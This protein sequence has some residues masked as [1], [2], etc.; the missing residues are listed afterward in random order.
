MS[1]LIVLDFESFYD[2]TYSLS[3]ITT[4]HYIRDP[5]F[6]A[7]GVSVKVNDGVPLWFSGPKPAIKKFLDQFPWDEATAV[8]HN[9][10]FDMAILNWHFDIR[11]KRIAC[12]LSMGRALH[13]I[14][15]G[16]LS[17]KALAEKYGLAPK[18]TYV[19][20]AM[21]M[22]RVD[23]TAEQLVDYGDYCAHDAQLCYELFQL[24]APRIPTV[25]L[26]LI[27]LTMR[28]FTEPVLELDAE[29]LT[30]HLKEIKEK[31][32]QLLSRALVDKADLMSG[33][34]F[35]ELLK[36]CGVE[37][38][39]KI[40]PTTGKETWAFAKTDE[41]LLALMD[42][43]N[44]IVQWLV[45]ARLGAK[46]TLEET[47]TERFLSVATRGTL[48]V[49]L[50]YYGGHT[51]R[52]S[53]EDYNIQNLPRK[54]KLKSSMR[55][56]EG[57]VIVEADSSQIECR[58]LAWNAE[59]A[60]LVELFE[61]NNEEITAGVP[62]EEMQFD[63]YRTMG[64]MIF[65]VPVSSITGTQRQVGKVCVLGCGFGLGWKKFISYAKLQG[66]EADEEFARRIISTYR[67]AYLR[68][69][70]LWKQGDRALEAMLDRRSAPLGRAGVL[71]VMDNEETIANI[72]LPNGMHLKYPNLRRW[73]DEE[74]GKKQ[75]IFDSP[76][77]KAKIK[78]AIWGG[79]LAENHTQALARIVL[80]E[81]MLVI[82]KRYK[83][84]L[85][86]HDSVAALV[87]KHEAEVG[88]AFIEGCMRTTPKWAKGLPLNCETKIGETYGG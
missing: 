44:I 22:R 37:P 67:E 74:T 62:K 68:I 71:T 12:T 69:P 80:G 64:S 40:S 33:D 61:K 14:E 35:A 86:V 79:Y 4:E 9:S 38:P 31:K 60:D 82:A 23:F 2:Q 21:G 45:S 88:R 48:P 39:T 87:P 7:I 3:K 73:D 46:S 83:V 57:F 29:L 53:G 15:G 85:T 65:G 52:W 18:G 8:A 50:R 51:G 81:Q 1:T 32:E 76:K 30:T 10:M 54:S 66:V 17:L 11:P 75:I 47:R 24:M 27:D 59:Q 49:P 56:P 72:R 43:E 6:E 19:Q 78:K 16:S 28:M 84:V 25:E 20:N 42:H 77:G 5:Q 58:S 41:G 26:R 63:P 36:A 55:A 70:L 13:G 34:K